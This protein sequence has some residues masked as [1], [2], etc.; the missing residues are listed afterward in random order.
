MIEGRDWMDSRKWS[1]WGD[2]GHWNPL[3]AN[4]DTSFGCG[5]MDGV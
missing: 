5:V 3:L 4:G 2:G 1:F